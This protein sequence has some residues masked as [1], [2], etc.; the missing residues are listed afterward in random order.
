M[1][2]CFKQRWFLTF[3]PSLPHFKT[4]KK[5]V[6]RT[7]D[8]L[9][10]ISDE[11]SIVLDRVGAVFKVGEK[12]TGVVTVTSKGS[13][14]HNGLVLNAMGRVACHSNPNPKTKGGFE[15]LAE[16]IKPVKA[17]NLEIE[18]TP[19][20][21]LPDGKVDLPFSFILAS[22]PTAEGKTFP[23]R[24][25]YQG[26]YVTSLYSCH[27]V[28]KKS[29]GKDKLSPPMTLHVEAPGQ[30]M[31][32]EEEM[33]EDKGV[34]F[35]MDSEGLRKSRVENPPKFLM[36]GE[37]T[38][39][40]NDI[41]VPLA[42]WICIRECEF[43]IASIELQLVRVEFC[44]TKEGVAKEHTEIQNI[45]I[46][47][48]DVQ[49]NFEIPIYMLFPKWYTSPIIREKHMRVDFDVHIVVTSTDRFQVKQPLSVKLFRSRD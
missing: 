7:K 32:S 11:I 10:M 19:G 20:G 46:G 44:A 31:P 41:D 28:M 1:T 30:G 35:R 13:Q 15:T 39:Y 33:A 17:L 45:Q 9:A 48:G 12:V 29:L 36:E 2:F 4:E 21:K 34:P 16:S 5:R 27:A 40:W 43:K 14:S 24:D 42:G 38:R 3:F 47:D 25:T 18:L 26:V 37:M 49:R 22:T 23:L 6:K 8:R